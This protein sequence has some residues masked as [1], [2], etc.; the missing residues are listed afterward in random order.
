MKRSQW[1]FNQPELKRFYPLLSF[2]FGLIKGFQN[3]RCFF[4]MRRKIK[5]LL[6][7]LCC[8]YCPDMTLNAKRIICV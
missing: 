3:L 4:D 8:F 7:A 2:T 6:A 1:F 5:C